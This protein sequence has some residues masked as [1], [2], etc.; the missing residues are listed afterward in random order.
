MPKFVKYL[1]SLGPVR[2]MQHPAQLRGNGVFFFSLCLLNN[3]GT[4]RYFIMCLY[5]VLSLFY[6][7]PNSLPSCNIHFSFFCMIFMHLYCSS[8]HYL[9]TP[10]IRTI[11]IAYTTF[12]LYWGPHLPRVH[13]KTRTFL[14]LPFPS[15]ILIWLFC[16]L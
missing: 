5:V 10:L 7:F 8:R 14:I 9:T 2:T 4:I 16:C 12:P 13:K 11:N 6:S 15:F 3:K 1:N